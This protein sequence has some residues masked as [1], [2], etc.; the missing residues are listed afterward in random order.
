MDK[1]RLLMIEHRLAIQEDR[2]AIQN[3]MGRYQY[4]MTGGQNDVIA[5]ELYAW[6]VPGNH[7]EYGPLGVFEGRNAVDFFLQVNKNLCRGNRDGTDDG[8]L[9]IHQLTTP[10]IEIAGDRKTAKGMWMSTGVIMTQP[11]E[12]AADAGDKTDFGSFH[13]DTG[14]YAVDFIRTSEGWKIWHLHV[15]DL[16]NTPFG[17]D[18]V[19][20]ARTADPWTTEEMIDAYRSRAAAGEDVRPMGF[21]IPDRPTTFHYSYCSDRPAPRMPLPPVPYD[22]FSDTFSY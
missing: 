3:L 7:C 6:D 9:E 1:T 5:E 8:T 22:T 4:L 20:N 21:P 17:V 16:W 2:Q 19:D 14:K 11:G 10:V 12:T 13:W 18:P 15:L